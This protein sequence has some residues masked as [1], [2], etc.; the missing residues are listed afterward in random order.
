M[1]GMAIGAAASA[2]P[3]IFKLIQSGKD[4]KL[5]QQ[6]LNTP[7]PQ[8]KTPEEVWRAYQRKQMLA[9][10]PLPGIDYLNEDLQERTSSG[11]RAMQELARPSEAAAGVQGLYGSSIDAQRQVAMD[12]AGLRRDAQ[13]D[14]A[15]FETDVLGGYKDKMFEI[16]KF[17]P[18]Q[19]AQAAAAALLKSSEQNMYGGLTGMSRIGVGLAGMMN[20]PPVEEQPT[21]GNFDFNAFF[22]P[23]PTA[24]YEGLQFQQN[25]QNKNGMQFQYPR[26][27]LQFGG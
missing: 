12:E 14:L 13:Q 7:R 19:N 24:D 4:K 17:Q 8:F 3:E 6:Y 10:E 5:A 16:N 27:K 11:V 15:G 1:A 20:T 23:T 18:Y 21:S 22:N 2:I 26:P 25:Y 9:G